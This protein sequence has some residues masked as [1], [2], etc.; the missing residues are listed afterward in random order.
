MLSSRT[1]IR[2]CLNVVKKDVPV[3]LGYI[4]CPCPLGREP[5]PSSVQS[6]C[7]TDFRRKGHLCPAMFDLVP[8]AT[9]GLPRPMIIEVP[10]DLR[11]EISAYA[12]GSSSRT[13]TSP[14]CIYRVIEH[15]AIG[16]IRRSPHQC[17][18]RDAP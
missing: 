13:P 15:F 18:K 7:F 6:Q 10:L 11:P 3:H 5:R 2:S 9:I 14:F 4:H 16:V 12:E 8:S 1:A 17:R